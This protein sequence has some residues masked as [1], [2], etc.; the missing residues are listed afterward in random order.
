MVDS[1]STYQGFRCGWDRGWSVFTKDV[2]LRPLWQILTRFY[3]A[4]QSIITSFRFTH[5]PF[6][7]RK[8]L[9][10]RSLSAV[11]WLTGEVHRDGSTC[12]W[13]QLQMISFLHV[14]VLP[15]LDQR[16]RGHID[17][18]LFYFFP[19]LVLL[20]LKV[21]FCLVISPFSYHPKWDRPLQQRFFYQQVS[22]NR[23]PA[24]RV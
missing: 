2:V 4:R 8:R 11:E 17:S 3:M 13:S 22:D 10:C 24:V 23:R 14:R 6:R 15:K 7:V 16:R 1:L 21:G 20:F 12:K 5:H 9:L 19:F 18:L